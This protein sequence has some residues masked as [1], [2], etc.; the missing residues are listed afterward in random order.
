MSRQARISNVKWPCVR[1]VK[2]AKRQMKKASCETDLSLALLEWRN[3]P[4]ETLAL[5][6]TQILMGR[7]TRT[8]MSPENLQLST[9]RPQQFVRLSTKTKLTRTSRGTRFKSP[10]EISDKPL[11]RSSTAGDLGWKARLTNV[12]SICRMTSAW[13]I[14]QLPDAFRNTSAPRPNRRQISK[15]G[16]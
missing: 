13:R 3:T 5:S 16:C 1:A 15:F 14:A 2:I 11:G 8:L 4:S 7:R 10:L 6:L 9:Q 12:Y